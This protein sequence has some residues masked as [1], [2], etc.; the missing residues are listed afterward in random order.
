MGCAARHPSY[1]LLL[2]VAEH[3]AFVGAGFI[4]ARKIFPAAEYPAVV[5]AGFI[6]A[7][8]IFPAAEYPAVVGAGFISARRT[9]EKLARPAFF[10]KRMNPGR[11]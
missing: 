3:P 6:P 2:P 5:G 8:K 7:R 1:A 11:G 10:K 4:P 9:R